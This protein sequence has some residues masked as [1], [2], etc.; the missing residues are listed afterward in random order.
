MYLNSLYNTIDIKTIIK[1]EWCE[2]RDSNSHGGTP[3][4][5]LNPARLPIPPLSPIW[6]ERWDSNPRRPESQSGALPTELRSPL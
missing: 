1:K 3:H 2:R 6:G 4:W 5:N